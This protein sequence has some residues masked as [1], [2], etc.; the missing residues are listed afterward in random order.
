MPLVVYMP[1]AKDWNS[2]SSI[3]TPAPSLSLSQFLHGYIFLEFCCV[4][5][6]VMRHGTLGELDSRGG[7]IEI[8]VKLP[9]KS[10]DVSTTGSKSVHN[11]PECWTVPV[12]VEVGE[13][14]DKKRNLSK[15]E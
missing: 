8:E 12:E 7:V 10:S 2:T 6:Q 5:G 13:F 3:N 9:E 14:S 1:V 15:N 4:L 11:M